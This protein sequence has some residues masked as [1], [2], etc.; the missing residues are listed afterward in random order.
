MKAMNVANDPVA[1]G[2]VKFADAG[3]GTVVSIDAD[4]AGAGA[5]VTLVTI[6]NTKIGASDYLWH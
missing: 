4:G 5:A 2:I 6:E 3:A 1:A